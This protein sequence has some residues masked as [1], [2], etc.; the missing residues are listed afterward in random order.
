MSTNSLIAMKTKEGKFR[1]V[2]CHSDGYL[3]YNGMILNDYYKDYNKVEKLINLGDIS[4]LGTDPNVEEKD[5]KFF[6]TSTYQLHTWVRDYK[7]WRNEDCPYVELDF[8][9]FNRMCQKSSAEYIYLFL[10]TKNGG[11][12]WLFREVI[13]TKKYRNLYEYNSSYHMSGFKPLTQKAI[14]MELCMGYLYQIKRNGEIL[15]SKR[16]DDETMDKAVQE[17]SECKAECLKTLTEKQFKTAYKLYTTELHKCYN[18]L[19]KL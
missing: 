3:G 16:Y 13:Y 6:D 7:R 12:R 1:F 4:S 10:P 5:N 15:N 2:Y 17:T 9:T 14:N 19:I 18:Y 11:Y 8:R